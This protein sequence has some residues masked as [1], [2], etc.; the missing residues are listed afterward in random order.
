[1]KYNKEYNKYYKKI[2]QINYNTTYRK[3]IVF[4][5]SKIKL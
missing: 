4:T 5:K 3:I 1:M 2:I